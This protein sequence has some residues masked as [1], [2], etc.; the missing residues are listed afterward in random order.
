MLVEEQG[1]DII[2]ALPSVDKAGGIVH[3]G[4][5]DFL[6]GRVRPYDLLYLSQCAA[7]D[8]AEL[9]ELAIEHE[10]RQ[11]EEVIDHI[12]DEDGEAEDAEERCARY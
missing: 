4:D 1:D 9:G 3:I 2:V 11:E 6:R 12:T 7:Y 8:I 5:V 10:L